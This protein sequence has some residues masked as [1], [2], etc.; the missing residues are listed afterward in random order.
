MGDIGIIARRLKDGHVQYGWSG[1]GGY[2][3]NTGLSLLEWYDDPDIIE[4]LFGIGEM[5]YIGAPGSENG[6]SSRIYT[7]VPAGCPHNLGTTEREI[8]SKIA[9]IDYG[10]FYD[11]DNKWYY[12]IPGPFRI[13]MPLELLMHHLDDKGH[14]FKYRREIERR[15]LT[16]IFDEIAVS[17]P[18]VMA[19]VKSYDKDV[20]DIKKQ[21]LESRF[22]HEEFFDKYRRIFKCFDDW[23]LC[24]TNEEETEI[25]GF[26]IRKKE[27]K[28]IETIEW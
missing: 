27:D 10:Y 23:V 1:N 25:I 17:D 5:K 11:L 9:F 7:T 14:E 18:D 15:L 28:H 3:K 21:V 24:C 16:Y 13:K 8:F 6:G 19:A 12:I 26:K 4:Y 22:P 2:F 20:Q